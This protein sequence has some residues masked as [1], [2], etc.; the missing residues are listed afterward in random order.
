MQGYEV[1]DGNGGKAWWDGKKLTPLDAQGFQTKPAGRQA[2]SPQ[3]AKTLAEQRTAAQNIRGARQQAYEFVQR[4]EATPTGG[5]MAVPG[6]SEVAGAF[7]PAISTLQGISNSMIPGLHTTPGPMTDA[8]AKLYKSA[9]PN[10]NL[11]YET[12]RNLAR[13]ISGKEQQIAAR[14]A[15]FESYA[16]RKGSLNGA[17][18]AF[19][20]WWGGYSRKGSPPADQGNPFATTK[21]RGPQDMSDD[22]LLAALGR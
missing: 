13:N 19:N 16:A 6:A 17:D 1:E 20:K 8:D 15:F 10:P 3:D 22:E 9:I 18:A 21:V 4:N 5:I 14:S 2:L 11:P 7:N 12:N